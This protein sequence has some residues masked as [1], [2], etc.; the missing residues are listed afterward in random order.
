M[1]LG[2]K[3]DG[4]REELEQGWCLEVKGM[5][6]GRSQDKN[7]P[8][9]QWGW[10]EVGARIGMMRG[11]NGDG[12][13]EELGQGWTLEVK[14]MGGGRSQD[15]DGPWKQREWVEGGARIRMDHGS[16][17]GEVERGGNGHRV[18]VRLHVYYYVCYYHYYY[19]CWCLLVGFILFLS[20]YLACWLAH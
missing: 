18:T 16:N 17:L 3:V 11:S 10:V 8:W 5:D 9:K 4:W 1:D 15:K 13:R 20:L 19:V 2:S 6:G 14:G 7:G 12:W